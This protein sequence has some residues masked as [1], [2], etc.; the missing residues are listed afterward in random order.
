[1]GSGRGEGEGGGMLGIG[2][3]PCCSIRRPI[4]LL[5]GHS[6]LMCS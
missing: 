1:M 2:A 6:S 4:M 3:R 5:V